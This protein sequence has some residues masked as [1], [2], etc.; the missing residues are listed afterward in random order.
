MPRDQLTVQQI[1]R[2][3]ALTPLTSAVSSANGSYFVCTGKEFLHVVNNSGG[4]LDVTIITDSLF[5]GNLT[6]SDLVVT[7]PNGQ[8]RFIGPFTPQYETTEPDSGDAR[9]ILIDW[10]TDSSV[11]AGV[12]QLPTPNTGQ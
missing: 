1:G 12:F 6:I 10:S 3:S 7:I 4:S 9:A 2:N 5:D 8:E 11:T